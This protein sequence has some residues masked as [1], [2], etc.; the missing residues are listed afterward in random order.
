MAHTVRSTPHCVLVLLVPDLHR[1]KEPLVLFQTTCLPRTRG[2]KICSFFA[3][4]RVGCV[5]LYFVLL[6]PVYVFVGC[7]LAVDFLLVYFPLS[8]VFLFSI[9]LFWLASINCL[10]VVFCHFLTTFARSYSLRSPLE[11]SKPG[12]WPLRP[13]DPPV[14][15]RLPRS[16]FPCFH[17]FPSYLA[18]S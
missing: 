1:E 11:S 10:P 13:A 16:T 9:S 2:E 14:L 3:V 5:V 6:G 12:A 4:D 7:H 8:R 18:P 15:R 17:L